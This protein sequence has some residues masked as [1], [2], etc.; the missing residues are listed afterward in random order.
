MADLIN[1]RQARKQQQRKA[2]EALATE[3]RARF[4]QTKATKQ[5][6]AAETLRATKVHDGHKRDSNDTQK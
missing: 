5:K 1:L 6:E 3:N 4:G 2:A